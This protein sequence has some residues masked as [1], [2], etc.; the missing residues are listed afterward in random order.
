MEGCLFLGGAINVSLE[1]S[2]GL[3]SWTLPCALRPGFPAGAETDLRLA[4]NSASGSLSPFFNFIQ[5]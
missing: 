1:S 4:Q 2:A 3:A 5:E